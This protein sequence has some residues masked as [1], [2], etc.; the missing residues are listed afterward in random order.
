MVYSCR[1]NI[2]YPYD[3]SGLTLKDN[4]VFNNQIKTNGIYFTKLLKSKKY[5][6]MFFFENGHCCCYACN[7]IETDCIDIDTRYISQIPQYWGVYTIVNNTIRI[8][9]V[10]PNRGIFEKFRIYEETGLILNDTTIHMMYKKY[11]EN[12]YYVIELNQR[13][14][15]MKLDSMPSSENVFMHRKT[16]K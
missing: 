14:Q 7:N 2:Q 5:S 12:T 3:E 9:R 6:I 11:P 16:C 10:S 1:S 8:Q 15:F 13:Y 4:F